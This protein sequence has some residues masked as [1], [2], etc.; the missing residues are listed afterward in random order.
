MESI[1]CVL[2]ADCAQYGL[3]AWYLAILSSDNTGCR[4]VR[5]IAIHM[6][7]L[8]KVQSPTSNVK[9]SRASESFHIRIAECRRKGLHFASPGWFNDSVSTS[10]GH[11]LIERLSFD[12]DPCRM[13]E[14]SSLRL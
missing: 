10:N 1:G 2:I 8:I 5:E 12:G 6:L 14:I 11:G 9:G 13:D 7:L 3:C 4:L